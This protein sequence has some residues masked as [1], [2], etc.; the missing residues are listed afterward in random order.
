LKLRAVFAGHGR[1]AH[2]SGV[3]PAFGRRGV[4]DPRSAPAASVSASRRLTH[5][6]GGFVEHRAGVSRTSG[7]RLGSSWTS[8][9]CN[10]GLG[11][12]SLAV[13]PPQP[14]VSAW[15]PNGAS[16]ALRPSLPAL[17]V[18]GDR[19]HGRGPAHPVGLR[20]AVNEPA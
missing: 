2:Y 17:A 7:L 18:G 4:A 3:C 5:P 12:A 10:G 6:C 8:D 15:G 16:A 19:W 1:W 13:T 11:R 14:A 9:L 20:G